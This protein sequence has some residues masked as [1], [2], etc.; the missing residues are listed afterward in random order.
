MDVF[1]AVYLIGNAQQ[2]WS[3]VSLLW[4]KEAER[5]PWSLTPSSHALEL[6]DIL[7]LRSDSNLIS[8]DFSL[9][10][11]VSLC[12]SYHRKHIP[13][14]LCVCCSPPVYPTQNN[15]YKH[16]FNSSMP[17]TYYFHRNSLHSIQRGC[18][19]Y[20][21][22]MPKW[23]AGSRS[24]TLLPQLMNHSVFG[25]NG[26]TPPADPIRYPPCIRS[27]ERWLLTIA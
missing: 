18:V 13:F 5:F 25:G 4:C 10:S 15:I 2:F 14:F 27:T 12:A 23:W 22:K 20:Y 9:R 19:T 8:L 6:E 16:H 11:F 21:W 24:C 1:G 3:G 7:H 17:V 26:P